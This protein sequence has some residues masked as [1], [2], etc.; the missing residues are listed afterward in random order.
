MSATMD[1]AIATRGVAY[2]AL[3]G[4][5]LAVAI[6]LNDQRYPAAPARKTECSPSVTAREAELARR[7]A[8]GAEAANE[9]VC[10]TVWD[11]NRKRFL[12]SDVRRPAS[13]TVGQL[14]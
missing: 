14:K 7:K 1:I 3:A 4:V 10:K 5:L 12:Q 8:I 9:V 13:E 11:A 2:V 6:T